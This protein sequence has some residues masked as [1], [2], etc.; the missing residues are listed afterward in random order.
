M[1]KAKKIE[2]SITNAN[3]EVTTQPGI[4]EEVRTYFDQLFKANTSNH[5]PVLSLITPKI[6]EEDNNRLLAPIT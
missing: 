2:K 6:T 4:C 3:V 1:T 5:K